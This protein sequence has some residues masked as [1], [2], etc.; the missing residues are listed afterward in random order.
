M[1]KRR[2]LRVIAPDGRNVDV[3]RTVLFVPDVSF[4]LENPK[5]CADGRVA[6]RIGQRR[7]DVS[8]SRMPSGV[9]DVNNLTLPAAEVAMRSFGHLSA[10]TARPCAPGCVTS[11]S[12]QLRV[13]GIGRV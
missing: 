3:A 10:P 5:H 13:L 9:E 8:R 4:F 6:R 1:M 7:L 2:T 12:Q 11:A